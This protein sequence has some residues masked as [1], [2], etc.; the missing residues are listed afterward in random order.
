[1]WFKGISEKTLIIES[2][3]ILELGIECLYNVIFCKTLIIDSLII[4][5]LGI[6]FP[7]ILNY[8]VRD[9]C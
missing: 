9:R 2:L 1:M 5:K 7:N 4:L 6:E 8:S 3:I